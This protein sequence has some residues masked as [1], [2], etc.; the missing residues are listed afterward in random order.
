MS[1]ASDSVAPARR[2]SPISAIT[3]CTPRLSD[4]SPRTRMASR[5]GTPARMNAASCR[6]R[7]ISSVRLI[8][9]LVS[10]S[11]RTL[12]FSS[13][14]L[15]ERSRLNSATRADVI[16]SASC[17]PFTRAPSGASATYENLGISRSQ[18]VDASDDF[19]DGRDVGVDQGAGLLAERAH[20][21]ALG[22]KAH[23]L[24]GRPLVEQHLLESLRH[25]EELIDAD[26]VRVT[27][28]RAEVAALTDPELLLPAAAD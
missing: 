6:E 7:C 3:R 2:S 23:G 27:R 12:C 10:S 28:P 20:A 15:T 1:K 24:V 13:S 18:G 16:V 11:W 9:V 17:S 5:I 21:F 4:S 22:E 14:F 25:A 26:T 8:L 19:G